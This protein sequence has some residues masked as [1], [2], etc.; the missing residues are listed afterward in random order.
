MS[1]YA[2]VILRRTWSEVPRLPC[3]CWESPLGGSYG[4]P[5]LRDPA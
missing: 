5:F 1:L 2:A 3:L 4:M